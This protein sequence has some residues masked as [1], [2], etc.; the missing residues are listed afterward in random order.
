MSE[1]RL[2]RIEGRLAAIERRLEALEEREPAP[3]EPEEGDEQVVIGAALAAVGESGTLLSLAGRAFLIL[4]GAFLV[5]AV[6]EAGA[7]PTPVGVFVGV[8]YAIVWLVLADR[9]GAA[10]RSAEATTLAGLSTLVGFPLAWE[11]TARF[12]VLPA[13]AAVALIVALAIAT[14][15]VAVRGG[16]RIAAWFGSLGAVVTLAA[17]VLSTHALLSAGAGCLILGAATAW[18][19]YGDRHW[20]GLRWPMALAADLVVLL[21]IVLVS[22]EGG[23]PPAYPELS[24]AGVWI[25]A[26]A[27]AA[28]YLGIFT[29][30]TLLRRQDI[31]LFA[32]LQGFAAAWIGFGGAARVARVAE[33]GLAATGWAATLVAVATYAAAFALLERGTDLR[34]SFRFTTSLALV[35]LVWGTTLFAQG[36]A[37]A[38]GW[39]LLSIVAAAISMRFGRAS[40]PVHAA[41]LGAAS[42]VVAGLPSALVSAFAAAP[43]AL[44]ELT[45]SPLL[46]ALL[47]SAVT[48]ALVVRGGGMERSARRFAAILA[49]ATTIVCLAVFLVEGLDRAF[50]LAASAESLA[51]WRTG[52]LALAAVLLASLRR[53]R[54]FDALGGFALAA[55]VCAGAELAI[56]LVRVGGPASLFAGFALFGLALL[57]VARLRRGRRSGGPASPVA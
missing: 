37:L 44:V 54:W 3:L 33:R 23:P 29:L 46:P 17:V 49:A 9:A 16:L 42:G 36:R 55:L 40:L 21:A 43:S 22:R 31:A 15:V 2:A 35:L 52:V 51:L 7:M 34:R 8:L 1:E 39:S 27:L 19:G 28:S 5:R 53:F 45:P 57:A 10:R 4:G 11:A 30:R 14:L 12:G 47:A 48:Y 6:T 13:P 38:I 24:P 25:L 32:A 18:L 50:D 26:V 41:L 20:T 56:G